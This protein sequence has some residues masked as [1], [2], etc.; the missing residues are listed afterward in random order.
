MTGLPRLII[1]GFLVPILL[2]THVVAFHRLRA[3]S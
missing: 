1:P 2:F 3:K